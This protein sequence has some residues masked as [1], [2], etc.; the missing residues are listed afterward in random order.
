MSAAAELAAT[1][2]KGAKNVGRRKSLAQTPSE[3]GNIASAKR[4]PKS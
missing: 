3:A 4:I 2:T 1:S